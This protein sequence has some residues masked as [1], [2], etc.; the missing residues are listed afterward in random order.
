MRGLR[1]FAENLSLEEEKL[2]FARSPGV[3]STILFSLQTSTS[4]NSSE[5]PKSWL[6]FN[7]IQKPAASSAAASLFLSPSKLNCYHI[8]AN[9]YCQRLNTLT[10]GALVR[11]IMK[12]YLQEQQAHSLFITAAIL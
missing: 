8:S 11:Y 5:E 4:S 3:L 7:R 9:S 12:I 1:D 2:N 6:A 10:A